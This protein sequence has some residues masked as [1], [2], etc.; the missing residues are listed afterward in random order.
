MGG[1]VSRRV[2]SGKEDTACGESLFRRV[3]DR[4][5]RQPTGSSTDVFCVTP[6]EV[7]EICVT[8]QQTLLGDET[9]VDVSAPAVVVGDLHGQFS[10]LLL[11]F[12]RCGHPGERPA[13]RYVF[14][15]DY[16]D[17]GMNSL[18]TL[19]LLLV[20]K[21]LYPRQVYLLRGNHE[22][23]SI[24]IVYGFYEE[25]KRRARVNGDIDSGTR[26]WK[27][28]LGVF[29]CLPVAALISKKIF[30]VHGGLSPDLEDI[31]MLR[32]IKRPAEL[33]E[34]G[35]LVDVLW[36]DPMT[37]EEAQLAARTGEHW[38]P[39]DRGV[40]FVFDQYVLKRFL[41]RNGLDLVCRGHMVVEEGYEFFGEMGLVTVFSAP[42]YS[43]QFDNLGA[44]LVI[45]ENL[46][47]SFES[48]E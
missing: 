15:G 6:E 36:S 33:P 45:A 27:Q 32:A 44:V 11:V 42:R 12:S 25:C 46:V 3:A 21:I 9:M 43:G 29:S 19:V 22:C 31:G 37:P 34:E 18:E 1:A 16:V 24:N 39:N 48:F 20:Y 13:Q 7:R 14:L 30:C 2:Y 23:A 40:S 41:E 47:C 4:L 5:C 17:R 35:V 38:L 28:F 8:A 26:V 10:D